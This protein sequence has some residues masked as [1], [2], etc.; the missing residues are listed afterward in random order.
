MRIA[1]VSNQV[2]ANATGMSRSYVGQLRA[3]IRT[4]AS[5]QFVARAGDFLGQILGEPGR[6]ATG[7]LAADDRPPSG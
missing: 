2:L 7:L 1:G 4:T 6:L 3:G 5:L